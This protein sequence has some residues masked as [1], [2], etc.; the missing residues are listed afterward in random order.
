MQRNIGKI[1]VIFACVV[2]VMVLAYV[3]SRYDRERDEIELAFSVG[4]EILIV[5]KGED[6]YYLFLPS[7][8]DPADVKLLSYAMEFEV[9]DRGIMVMRGTDLGN[10]P[11]NEK[12]SCKCIAT[13]EKFNFCVMRSENLP[14]VFIETASGKIDG[15]WSDKTVEESG[16]IQVFDE[17]G[18]L[19]HKSGLKSIKCRGNY[20]FAH[21]EKKSM[22]L[23]L[24]EELSLLGL[25]KGNKYVLVANAS[26]PTLIRNHIARQMEEALDMD[27]INE[28]RFVDLYANGE[29]LGNYY[30]CESLEIGEER[31]QIT[32]LE[33]QMDQFYAKSGY[34][35]FPVY[36]TEDKKAKQLTYNPADIT[37]GYLVEREFEQRYLDEYAQNASAFRT[38]LGEHFVLKSPVYCSQEEVD[39]LKDFFDQ[40]EKALVAKDGINPDTKRAYTEYMDV[41]SLVKKYLVEEVTKNYDGG[42]SSNYFYKDSDLYDGRIKAGPAWDFDMSMGN[43]LDWMEDYSADPTGLTKLAEHDHT[44]FW[45]ETL[46]EK[47]EVYDKI[48]LYYREKLVPYLKTLLAEEIDRYEEEL[49]ASAAMNEVRWKVDFY[50]NPYY[51]DRATSFADMKQYMLQRMEFLNEIWDG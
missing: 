37:G 5:H 20:S 22:N 41:D 27:Y 38:Q 17:N 16:K 3:D 21:F 18:A 33:A 13:R 15:I 7:Y 49:R 24:K 36:E 42:V 45:F 43:Y 47:E 44:L 14:T 8:A 25:G 1:L 11:L 19:L 28:A 23:D 32:D 12:L 48:C 34:D 31:I 51:S 40:A 46:Y 4:N 29:Y 30:L 35:S 6:A 39:Y 10:I 26:D 2:L 9:P 50:N